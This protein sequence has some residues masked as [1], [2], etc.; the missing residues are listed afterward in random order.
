MREDQIRRIF[1]C[2]W[3]LTTPSPFNIQIHLHYRWR[4]CVL[5]LKETVTCCTV[6]YRGWVYHS[7]VCSKGSDVDMDIPCWSHLAT[8]LANHIILQQPVSNICLDQYHAHTKHIDICYHF[9]W[10]IAE[11]GII[12]ICYCPTSDMP[13]DMLMKAFPSPQLFHLWQGISEVLSKH[14]CMW[15]ATIRLQSQHITPQWISHS[16]RWVHPYYCCLLVLILV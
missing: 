16:L 8:C 15:L 6:Y 2:R 11:Q 12:S 14:E 9:I 10:D 5:E 3:C 13:A 7:H 4:S 1:G